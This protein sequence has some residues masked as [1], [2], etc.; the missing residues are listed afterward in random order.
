MIDPGELYVT[1]KNE[2]ISTLL[3][4]CV[5]AC[6]YDP[7]NRVIGMNHFL[8]AQQHSANNIPLLSTDQGR[9]GI[10]AMELLINGMLK[11][12][13]QR[14]HLKAKAFGGGDV[15]KLGNEHRG[16][17]SIGAS[18]VEFIQTFLTAERIPLIT[19]GLSGNIGRNIFFLAADYSVYVKKIDAVHQQA[20][21]KEER[22]FLDKKTILEVA[23][24]QNQADFW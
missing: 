7:V 13:A 23:S 14:V 22:Q 15:L 16:D 2:I 24:A 11:Q 1:K 6:L 9:Y 20:V 10:H 21:I 8:L 4:S 5:A 12:G 18:N 19:S 3:G 17:K